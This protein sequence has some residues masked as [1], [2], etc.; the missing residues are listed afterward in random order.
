MNNC[1]IT[2][3]IFL[4]LK[5]NNNWPIKY[6]KI[7]MIFLYYISFNVILCFFFFTADILPAMLTR[8]SPK[9]SNNNNNVETSK[10]HKHIGHKHDTLFYSALYTRSTAS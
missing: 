5:K 3:Y 2:C 1:L 6:Y 9:D 10:C 7:K 8:Q 4:V